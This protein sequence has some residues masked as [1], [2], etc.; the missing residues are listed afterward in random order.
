VNGISLK[1]RA[2]I[3]KREIPLTLVPNPNVTNISFYNVFR[4]ALLLTNGRL[5]FSVRQGGL[6]P[7][8]LSRHCVMRQ[9]ARLLNWGGSI[10]RYPDAFGDLTKMRSINAKRDFIGIEDGSI[11]LAEIDNY[12]NLFDRS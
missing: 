5:N 11:Y 4:K 1:A 10:S 3:L 2:R 8:R 7:L 12:H 6:R 9:H